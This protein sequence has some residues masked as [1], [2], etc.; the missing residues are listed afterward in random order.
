MVI[1]MTLNN[2]NSII[3][4]FEEGIK[5]SIPI[6]YIKKIYIS[7]INCNGDEIPYEETGIKNKLLANFI[8]LVLNEESFEK[9][10]FNIIKNNNIYSITVKFNTGKTIEFITPNSNNPFFSKNHNSYQKE[11]I[12]NNNN[13]IM[14]SEYKIKN[15]ASILI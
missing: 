14:I 5:L 2:A 11:Y 8:I 4:N 1:V 6:D 15:I 12:I 9:K 13:A 10:E 3:L 7:N